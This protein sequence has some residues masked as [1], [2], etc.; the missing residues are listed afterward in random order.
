M[1]AVA[2]Q[3]QRSDLNLSAENETL[4]VAPCS[5]RVAV[6]LPVVKELE[7]LDITHNDMIVRWKAAEGASGYMILYAPLTEEDPGDEKE[8]SVWACVSADKIHQTAAAS[9]LIT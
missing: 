5:W 6:E 1:L 7:L 2:E 4:H 3:P 9:E 8:V